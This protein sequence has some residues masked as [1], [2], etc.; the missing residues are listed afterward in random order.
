MALIV[1]IILPEDQRILMDDLPRH[2]LVDQ[3][4]EFQQ[5]DMEHREIRVPCTTCPGI[6]EL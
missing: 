6:K 4:L 2:Q 1:R 3:V 5:A